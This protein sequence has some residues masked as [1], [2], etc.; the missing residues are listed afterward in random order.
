ML[1]VWAVSCR[2]VQEVVD[3]RNLAALYNPAE[4]YLFPQTNIYHNSDTKSTLSVRIFPNQ[5][6]INRANPDGA[7]QGDVEIFYQLFNLSLGGAKADSG[8]YRFIV[9]APESEKRRTFLST[10]ELKAEKGN[11]YNLQVIMKDRNAERSI[12]MYLPFEKVSAE[13]R[14]H[15]QVFDKRTGERVFSPIVRKNQSVY[16]RTP[17]L[18]TDSLYVHYFP[19]G[20]K[21]PDPPFMQLPT[22]EISLKTDDIRAV[23]YSDTLT[24]TFPREGT[25]HITSRREGTEGVS[26]FNFGPY[27]PSIRTPEAM[28]GPLRYLMTAEQEKEIGSNYNLKLAVENFWINATGNIEQARELLRI[29]YN[30]VLFSNFYFG[31]DKE[32]W[33]TDRGMIYIIYGPPDRLYKTSDTEVWGY[34]TTVEENKWGYAERTE[35][36][37]VN[38]YFVRRDNPFTATDFI[39]SRSQT[40]TTYWDVALRSWREGRVFLLNNPL[41]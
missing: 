27:Y 35:D 31:A 17:R 10:I 38:F 13:S 14:Y 33:R 30:R 25:Y 41:N 4:N 37:Y 15:F 2:P 23:E 20:D 1:T 39:L 29:Y 3:P 8:S 16:L 24:F 19:P 6:L 22:P 32:G 36:D 5:L 11:T 9:P 21:I 26:F 7:L 40:V 34:E 12:Q 18:Q 28:F